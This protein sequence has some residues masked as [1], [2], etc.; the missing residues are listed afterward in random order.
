[1]KVA[2]ALPPLGS[3]SVKKQ[4]RCGGNSSGG[5]NC[6]CISNSCSV[7]HSLTWQEHCFWESAIFNK[8]SY[9]LPL[10]HAAAIAPYLQL[11][12]LASTAFCSCFLRWVHGPSRRD[13]FNVPF[14]ALFG[15][16]KCHLHDGTGSSCLEAFSGLIWFKLSNSQVCCTD[17]MPMMPKY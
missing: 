9:S 3:H 4:S 6:H 11:S 14:V 17:A 1:M 12:R 2:H 13:A 7:T 5:G 16:Q 15:N 10:N 8:S